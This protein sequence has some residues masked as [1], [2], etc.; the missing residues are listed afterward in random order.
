MPSASHSPQA[1]ALTLDGLEPEQG[2]RTVPV[3]PAPGVR[4]DLGRLELARAEDLV[5][6]LRATGFGDLADVVRL[7]LEDLDRPPF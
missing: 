7:E 4:I 1:G 3:A 2:P 5:V 6:V